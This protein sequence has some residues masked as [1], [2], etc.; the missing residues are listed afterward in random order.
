[1]QKISFTK[2]VRPDIT[3]IQNEFIDKYMLHADGEYVKIYL[4]LLRLISANTF[5]GSEQLADLLELTE[6]DVDRALR[7]WEK[8]GLI[9]ISE[10]SITHTLSQSDGESEPITTSS[11]ALPS[12]LKEDVTENTDLDISAVPDTLMLQAPAKSELAPSE[13]Q[14]QVQKAE[15]N[16]S[17]FMAESFLGRPLTVSELNSFCYIDTALNFSPDLLEYLIE[18]CVCRNKKNV[19]YMETVAINW[20][21]NGIDSVEKAKG[22]ALAY[23]ANTFRIMKAFGLNNRNPGKAELDM[24]KRWNQMPFEFDIIEEAIN[25]TLITTNKASFN[26][27]NSILENWMKAG[28]RDLKDIEALDSKFQA[29]RSDK[30]PTDSS[31]RYPNNQPPNRFHNFEQRNY[32]YDALEARL[33]EKAM[34][35]T[36]QP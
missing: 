33:A 11:P 2:D 10:D 13:I 12:T 16:H 34:Q 5:K 31:R 25:R 29:S 20:Y 6:R 21:Q 24:I 14:K 27:A 36:A 1:M 26:Y 4:L 3:I 17:T 9:N 28:V 8:A 15:L 22:Q 32:D 30:A 19:R 35:K 18:Y 7:H 23:S